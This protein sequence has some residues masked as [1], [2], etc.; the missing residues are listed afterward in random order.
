MYIVPHDVIGGPCQF[1]CQRAMSYH[2]VCLLQLAVVVGPGIR[3]EAP[4]QLGGL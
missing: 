3:I 2:E 1:V 4:G